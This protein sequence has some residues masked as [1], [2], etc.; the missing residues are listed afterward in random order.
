[1]VPPGGQ[2]QRGSNALYAVLV[3]NLKCAMCAQ[4]RGY[5][6]YSQLAIGISRT[7]SAV[8]SCETHMCVEPLWYMGPLGSLSHPLRGATWKIGRLGSFLIAAWA[9][10]MGARGSFRLET[11]LWLPTSCSCQLEAGGR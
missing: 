11:K 5:T 10:S 1:M 6:A 4:Q 3:L 8:Q 2:V 9:L 7:T